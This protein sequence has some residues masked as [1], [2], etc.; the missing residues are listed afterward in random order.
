MTYNDC[1]A[2]DN[3]EESVDG[4]ADHMFHEI[5]NINTNLNPASCAKHTVAEMG[6]GASFETNGTSVRVSQTCNFYFVV[7]VSIK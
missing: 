6:L 2:Q 1:N 7:L 3:N 4:G 5:G